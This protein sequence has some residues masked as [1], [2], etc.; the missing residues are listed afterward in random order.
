LAYAFQTFLV[1]SANQV[2]NR[3]LGLIAYHSSHEAIV[4]F[5]VVEDGFL[6]AVN[7]FMNVTL[8][9]LSEFVRKAKLALFKSRLWQ[10]WHGHQTFLCVL[11]LLL[12]VPP[13]TLLF[14][15]FFFT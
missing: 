5:G 2:L 7:N 10:I 13:L 8:L 15:F 6:I 12:L 9:Y 1:A 11:N 3:A 4:V 14:S